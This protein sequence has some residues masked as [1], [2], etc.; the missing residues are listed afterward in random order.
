MIDKKNIPFYLLVGG[1][2]ILLKF[3]FRFADNDS[4]SFLLLPLNKMVAVLTGSASSYSPEVGYF[5]SSLN[6]IIDK[7]CSGYNFMLLS[8]VILSYLGLR[9]FEKTKAKIGVLFSSFLVAWFVSLFVSA[10]R[11]I[12]SIT[13]QGKLSHLLPFSQ[14]TIHEGVGVVMNLTFLVLLYILIEKLLIYR[15]YYE[16]LT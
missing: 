12:A 7:S 10:S 13:I 6:I 11:I 1:L 16:K 15:K 8:F 4:M 2:F 5:H 3:G 9:D 14:S